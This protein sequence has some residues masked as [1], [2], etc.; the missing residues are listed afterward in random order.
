M[1]V[2]ILDPDMEEKF[3]YLWEDED[4]SRY[5]E[6]W[7][8][9]LIVPPLPNNEHQEVQLALAMPFYHVVVTGNLGHAYPGVNVSDRATGWK[10]NYRG[11]DVVVYLH[12]NPAVNHGTH[13]QG[14]PDFL[15]EIRSPGERPHDKFTFY[16]SVNTREVLIVDRDPWAVELFRL[17]GGKLVSVGRSDLANPAVLASA[18][19]PLTFRLVPGQPRPRVEVVHPPTGRRWEA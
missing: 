10:S 1:P 18:V 4:A 16:E 8:G 13:W 17:T 2:V 9:V 19:V 6:V 15:V 3:R 12:S 11:P 7:E 5:D 14:G